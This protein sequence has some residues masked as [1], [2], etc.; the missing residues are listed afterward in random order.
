MKKKF[1]TYNIEI[2]DQVGMAP[3]S[4]AF[5]TSE[6]FNKVYADSW[7]H[8]DEMEFTCVDGYQPSFDSSYFL[9]GES[10]LAFA[11]VDKNKFTTD[12]KSHNKTDVEMGPLYLVWKAK[13]GSYIYNKKDSICRYQLILF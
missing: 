1:K 6:V 13:K 10:Y 2:Y 4:E 3:G 5:K 9:K 12:L 11:Y 8:K 7:K